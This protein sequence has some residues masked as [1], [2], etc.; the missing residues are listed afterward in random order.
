M[1]SHAVSS[2]QPAYDAAQ[3]GLP[4]DDFWM[5]LVGSVDALLRSYH[6]IHEFTDDPDC[7]LRIAV[8]HACNRVSLS[9]GTCVE[10]G[11]R[12]GALHLWN[13][14]LPRYSEAGPDVGWAC[15]MRR[16]VLRSMRLLAV[17]VEREPVCKQ[18]RAFCAETTLSNRLG[19]LQIR[20]L[21]GRY[22][23]ERIEPPASMLRRLHTLGDCLNTWALTRAYNPAALSRQPFLRGRYELWISRPALFARYGRQAQKAD[24]SQLHR[25]A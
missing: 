17:F 8:R 1:A 12:V 3:R 23:F 11:E 14:H 5:A 22:G 24:E 21:A 2:S 16:R 6:G 19:D 25:A 7:V 10:R 9:D 18:I 15:D 13:E 20:R 4:A